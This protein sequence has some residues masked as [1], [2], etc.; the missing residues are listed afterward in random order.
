MFWA[1]QNL[2][3]VTDE[4]FFVGLHSYSQPGG[5]ALIAGSYYA[6]PR[7]DTFRGVL[8]VPGPKLHTILSKLIQELLP[9]L[10]LLKRGGGAQ[11]YKS[12]T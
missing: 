4:G 2:P 5:T 3:E 11:P 10:L 9:S 12:H 8:V 7:Q 1:L 6:P